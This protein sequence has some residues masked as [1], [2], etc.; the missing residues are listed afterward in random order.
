VNL[1]GRTGRTA[2]TGRVTRRED[3]ERLLA[4]RPCSR[5]AHFMLHHLADPG[6]QVNKAG[7]EDV[8][9]A[10]PSVHQ[11][12][13]STGRELMFTSSVDNL[14]A[15]VCVGCVVPKR[16]AR[17][18]VTRNL[19]RR[20]IHAAVRRQLGHMKPGLWAVRLRAGFDRDGFIS[21]DSP[22]LRAAVRAELDSL[23]SRLK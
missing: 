19:V 23:L 12:E 18:A 8:A 2:L 9:H 21:A 4:V 5:S 6:V 3:F 7:A 14:V 11:P 22:A 13:L 17:R 15:R 20:Q 10:L 1:Q 16:H